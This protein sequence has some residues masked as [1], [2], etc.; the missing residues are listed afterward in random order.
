MRP[1]RVEMVGFPEFW[2]KSHDVNAAAFTAIRNM[3][4]IQ[5]ELFS[6]QVSERLHKVIRRISK[7]TYNSLGALTTILLNGYG[8]DGMKV[9]R[10]MFEA[11]VTVSYLKKYPTE[12]D[13]YLEFYHILVKRQ[14]NY[15]DA[16]DPDRVKALSAER[17]AQIE[18]EYA[19]VRS[20]FTNKK[21]NIRKSWCTMS[22]FDM[23]KEVDREDHYRTFYVSASGMHHIDIGGI[24]NQSE[25]ESFDVDVAPSLNWIDIALITGHGATITTMTDYNEIAGHGMDIKL[26]I[27]HEEFKNAWKR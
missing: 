21:G 23:A 17:R 27:A 3:N 8:N 25:E 5:E 20:R 19:R 6:K 18:S 1:D 11:G 14:L 2:Q 9:A 13:D 15:L 4:P 22:I 12:I 10:S 24:A 7:M 26:V 16:E